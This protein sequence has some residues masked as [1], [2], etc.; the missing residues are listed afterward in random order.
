MVAEKGEGNVA[1]RGWTSE[2]T[3][4]VPRRLGLKSEISIATH[5][6]INLHVHRAVISAIR[7][8]A[9]E[10]LDF[11][12]SLTSLMMYYRASFLSPFSHLYTLVDAIRHS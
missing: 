12:C 8:A 6:F 4:T 11:L 1:G 9:R 10:L 7:F 5:V 3:P 2:S